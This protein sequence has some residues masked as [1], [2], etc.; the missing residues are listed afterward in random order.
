MFIVEG[1]EEMEVEIGK[2]EIMLSSYTKEGFWREDVEESVDVTNEKISEAR[3]SEIWPS[4]DW[5][6]G[7]G[8]KGVTGKEAEVENAEVKWSLVDGEEFSPAKVGVGV[9]S[10][11]KEREFWSTVCID[12]RGGISEDWDGGGEELADNEV[13]VRE[14]DGWW[15]ANSKAEIGVLASRNGV[16]K[17]EISTGDEERML[18]V[19][20]SELV[21]S[22]WEPKKGLSNR[23]VIDNQFS[24][25]LPLWL[26][27]KA[28]Q[29]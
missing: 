19:D 13:E 29:M 8:R 3:K 15:S 28:T 1:E 16:V 4:V 26:S 12:I 20:V 27:S 11:E 5:R 17:I 18:N 6:E 22:E 10:E 2:S 9:P 14:P 7:T 23:D 24:M 21:V 25:L